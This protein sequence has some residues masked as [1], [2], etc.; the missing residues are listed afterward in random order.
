MNLGMGENLIRIVLDTNILIS[1]IAYGGKPLQILSLVI[2][3]QIIATT[4]PILLAELREILSKKFLTLSSADLE[5]ALHQISEK[6]ITINPK[7]ALKIVKDDDDNRVLEAAVEGRCEYIIT[8]DKELLELGT[9]KNI[10]I[11]TADQFL[12]TLE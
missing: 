11:V 12:N 10:K 4:S 8:G 9:F 2:E 1:A 5:L 3:N 7:I 6:F